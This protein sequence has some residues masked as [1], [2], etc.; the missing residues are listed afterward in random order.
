M[1]LNASARARQVVLPARG[2]RCSRFRPAPV[3]RR[4]A[5]RTSATRWRAISSMISRAVR[6]ARSR[7]ATPWRTRS[8]SPAALHYGEQVVDL[9]RDIGAE[10]QQRAT[11]RPRAVR[12]HRRNARRE[13]P[14]PGLQLH[15][16]AS[17]AGTLDTCQ[18]GARSGRSATAGPEPSSSSTLERGPPSL[19]VSSAPSRHRPD[20]HSVPAV[21]LAGLRDHLLRRCRTDV[22]LRDGLAGVGVDQSVVTRTSRNPR[23]TLTNRVAATRV[24]A[25]TRKASE[26]RHLRPGL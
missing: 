3:R 5:S 23:L 4:A 11:A 25:T 18:V 8:G 12:V 19:P 20:P 9:V 7:P 24:D 22:G 14:P 16:C 13:G 21:R 6:P 2:S 1:S 26:R 10:R 17:S 15:F